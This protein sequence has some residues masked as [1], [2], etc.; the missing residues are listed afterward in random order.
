VKRFLDDVVCSSD[1]KQS[2]GV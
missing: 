1:V 2:V